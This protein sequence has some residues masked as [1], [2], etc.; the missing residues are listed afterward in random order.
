M[1]TNGTTVTEQYVRTIRPSNIYT[2]IAYDNDCIIDIAYNIGETDYTRKF[3]YLY[4]HIYD[5]VK[6]VVINSSVNIASHDLAQIDDHEFVVEKTNENTVVL[7]S[8]HNDLEVIAHSVTA[9]LIKK[10]MYLTL[11]WS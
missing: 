10:E 7:A 3:T 5:D 6:N 1:T 4:K 11:S 2:D 8:A 9:N